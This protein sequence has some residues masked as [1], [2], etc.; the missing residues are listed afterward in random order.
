MSPSWAHVPST[1][2]RMSPGDRCAY[3]AV[4]RRR[5]RLTRPSAGRVRACRA[6][7][8]AGRPARAC[9]LRVCDCKNIEEEP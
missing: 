1:G 2:V 6:S 3:V 8:R 9:A 4:P 5:C 7:D